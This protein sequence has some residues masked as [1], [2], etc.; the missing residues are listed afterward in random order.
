MKFLKL[1]SNPEQKVQLRETCKS[2]LDEAERIKTAETFSTRSS[3]LLIDLSSPKGSP[4]RRS[5]SLPFRTA[6]VTSSVKPQATHTRGSP[7]KKSAAT[8]LDLNL[9]VS[10]RRLT[11]Q[12][13]IL[14]LKASK[15]NGFTFPPWRDVPN[16]T[17]F[18]LG[19][20]GVPFW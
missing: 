12:E 19:T 10:R 8:D 15:L 14:L 3:D 5:T 1:A 2:L 11:K 17:E 4:A 7:V 18:E 20:D 16:L 9:P 6:D 13:E